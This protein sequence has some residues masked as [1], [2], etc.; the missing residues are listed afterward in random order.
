[1]LI[2]LN[3]TDREMTET[4]SVKGLSSVGKEIMRGISFDFTTGSSTM[5][6]GPREALFIAFGS[7]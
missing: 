7:D 4:V 3:D 5:V 1:M 6:L 2:L